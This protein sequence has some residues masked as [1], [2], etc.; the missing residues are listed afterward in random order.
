RGWHAPGAT[1]TTMGTPGYVA[2]EVV[3]SGAITARSDVYA[4]GAVIY[5]MVAGE[6]PSAESSPAPSPDLPPRWERVVLRCLAPQPERRFAHGAQVVRALSARWS[7]RRALG[8]LLAAAVAVVAV[9][10]LRPQPVSPAPPSVAVLP[11]ENAS[12]DGE[13]AWLSSTLSEML[14]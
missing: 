2:P 9:V 8:L 5:R 13:L 7:G 3:E 11:L 12:G 14:A 10:L 4:L 6:L 1:A